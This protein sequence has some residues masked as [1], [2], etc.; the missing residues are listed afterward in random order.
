M[1]NMPISSSKYSDKNAVYLFYACVASSVE[2]EETV[3]SFFS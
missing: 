3:C 1:T 2:L